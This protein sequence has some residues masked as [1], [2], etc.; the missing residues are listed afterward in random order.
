MK[1]V[2]PST[3]NDDRLPGTGKQADLVS[4]EPQQTFDVARV[5]RDFPILKTII[6]GH[7]LTFLDSAASAQ[8]PSCVLEALNVF[9]TGCYSNIHRGVY[10][11]SER[12]TAAYE[13]SRV[14]LRTLINAKETEEI[15]F[16]RG[17]TE[18]INLVANSFGQMAVGEGD[19][20]LISHMEHHSNIVPWQ[21]L[22]ERTG[23][24]LM[25]VPIDDDGEFIFEEYEKL[26]GPRTKLV[27]VTHQ[28][29]SL[30]TVNPVK[31]ITRRAHEE[32]AVVLIDGAQAIAHKKIDV[33]DIGCDF[34][35]FSGH[36]MFGPTGVGVLYGR[37]E[38]L[39]KMPPWQG[40]GDMIRT[41][42][43]EGTTY[44]DL[45]HKFEAGTPDIAGGIGLGTAVDYL[46]H[47]DL[48]LVGGYEHELLSY[49]EGL[50]GE[51]PE[52]RIIGRA[53][54]K[55]AVISFVIDGIHPHDIGTILDK[56]GIAIRTGHHCTQP[57]MHRFGVPATA[58]ASIACYNT[59]EELDRLARGIR[60]VLE[61]FC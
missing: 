25:V 19:E 16:L 36:K 47:L 27:A 42:S 32:G 61:V 53:K 50:L 59:K 2:S 22:C 24:K 37:R 6:N 35:A 58:R 30:G 18:A 39:E 26:L 10:A 33:R 43:F 20:I 12:A 4:R 29:N 38:I 23:A 41:V 48:D 34:Y 17:T 57:V 40:G 28:S 9:Y 7:P 14:K 56:E 51:F 46:S 11:L 1:P 31:E 60:T 44:A 52:I 55:S 8:K 49:G 21:L 54:E 45:P 5:R 3:R 13:E 15:I